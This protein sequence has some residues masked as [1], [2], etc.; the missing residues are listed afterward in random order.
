MILLD[1]DHDDQPFWILDPNKKPQ[2]E[3]L[4]KKAR[5]LKDFLET[6]SSALTGD[7]LQ[8]VES[9]I[10]DAAYYAEDVLESHLVKQLL[11][12]QEGQSFTSFPPDLEEVIED[13]DYAKEEMMAI[14]E[15]REMHP[16]HRLMRRQP[17]L[18]VF[19]IVGM[20]GIGKTTLAR[21]LYDDPSVI[22]QF[23]I[24]AWVTI[25]QDYSLREILLSLLHCVI[26]KHTREL[27]EKKNEELGSYLLEHLGRRRYLIVLDD[28]WDI[29]PWDDLREYFWNHKN[30]SRIIVTTRDQDVVDYIGSKSVHEIHLER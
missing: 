16:K 23:D 8:R 3:S 13:F 1:P 2:I 24:R 7:R 12:S 21:N 11:S 9:R 25:S 14:V 22:S 30:G 28:I 5:F 18:D 29:K 20:G 4:L 27:L 10:R 15:G 19:V 17:N 26:G 6:S